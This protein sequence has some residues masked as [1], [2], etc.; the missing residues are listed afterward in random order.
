MSDEPRRT[1]KACGKVIAIGVRGFF[2]CDCKNAT[3]NELAF[4]NAFRVWWNGAPNTLGLPVKL[5]AS[6]KAAFGGAANDNAPEAPAVC[7]KILFIA[8][9][10]RSPACVRNAGHDGDCLRK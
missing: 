4:L 1:C 6:A 8:R 5:V 7:G 10:G 3:E 2:P 9:S